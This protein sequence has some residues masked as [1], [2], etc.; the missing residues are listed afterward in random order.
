MRRF[1]IVRSDTDTLTSHSGLA[2]VGRALGHTRLERELATIPLRHGIAHADCVKSYVGLLCTAKSDFEAIENRRED[3]FFEEALDVEKVP[4]APSLRQRFDSC[5]DA[6]LPIVDTASADFLS[7]VGAPITPIM[8]RYGTSLRAV[9][10]KYVVLDIDV[11]PMDNSGTKKEGVSY[12]YKGF[13]G[14]APLAA[15]L[16]EEGWCLACE[17]RPG[18]QHGQKEF[19]YFLERVVPR[20]KKLTRHRLL[21]RLDSGHDAVENRAW[22]SEEHVDFIIRW[23]PRR[24]DLEAWLK[25]AEKEAAWTSPRV[26]KRVGIFSDIVAEEHD[27]DTRAV[28]RVMRVTERTID[29]DGNRL[30]VPQITV[31]GW[32][33]SLGEVACADEKVIALY[34]D[35]ATSEQFHSEFKTDLD[36]ER[37]PS[38][39]FAT[40]DLVMACAVLAYNI[41]RWIGLAG[42]LRDDA[43][44][45]HAAKRRRLKTVIQELMSVAARVVV[46]GRRLALKFSRACP[47]FPSFAAV[48]DRLAAT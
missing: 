1:E 25:R 43:P 8:I 22:F 27:G 35:H 2:L 33:T 16:G 7:R 21:A 36:I 23:N 4:S 42:L 41:L 30:L 5:A 32:W 45:R 19:I 47:A 38:G 12:T 17:L 26:G 14:Y 28:R 20:A 9:K 39:K 44:V 34:C 29:R 11:F 15:Y 48:Y 24:Q 31:E 3:G 37:L 10:D 46:S 6:M 40:N 18:S 13:N